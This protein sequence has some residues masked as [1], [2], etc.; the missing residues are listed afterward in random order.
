VY[1]FYSET[2]VATSISRA[3]CSGRRST[4][5]WGRRIER[6]GGRMG[7]SARNEG[8][9]GREPVAKRYYIDRRVVVVIGAQ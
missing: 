4:T 2:K 5:I 8:T 3:C 7:R 9:G 6:R 1:E